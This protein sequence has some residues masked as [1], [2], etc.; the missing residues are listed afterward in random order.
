MRSDFAYIRTES[1]TET[2]ELLHEYGP[3][4]QVA[5]GM[6]DL[7]IEVKDGRLK[8]S[9]L[10]DISRLAE[11]KL[12][13]DRGDRLVLGPLATHADIG[14]SPLVRQAAGVLAEAAQS[15]G[16]PQI[17]NVGTIGGNIGNASPAADTLPA[18]TVLQANVTVTSR[19]GQRILPIT[20][21][22]LGPYRTVLSPRELIT[23]ISI[24]RLTGQPRSRFIKLA[25][26][27]ALATSRL[28]LALLAFF[29][30]ARLEEIRISAG[31]TTPTPCRLREAESFLRDQF[32]SSEVIVQAA[33]LASREMIRRTGLRGSSSYK[34]PA[35]QGL[36]INALNEMTAKEVAR[37]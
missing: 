21:I 6:T 1:L 19:E 23:E 9:L 8:S 32:L 28:S 36:F 18:L 12:I 15:I 4:A 20:E 2:L 16:S 33:R 14:A 22:F 30:D 31:A 5:A 17:R 10:I 29:R 24:P 35:L 27:K 26:R 34:V 37:C 11:L 7:M 3:Q 13:E 25:R